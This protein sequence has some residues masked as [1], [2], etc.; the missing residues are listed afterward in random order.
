MTVQ[1]YLQTP[2]MKGERNDALFRAVMTARREGLSEIEIYHQLTQKALSDGLSESEIRSTINSGMRTPMDEKRP[3]RTRKV[4]DWDSIIGPG[5]LRREPLALPGPASDWET[6]DFPRF[7]NALF[8][9]DEYVSYNAASKEGKPRG[10]GKYRQTRSKLLDR[11]KDN[12]TTDVVC[13][14]D[15]GAW[16]R[17]NPMDGEGIKDANVT[18]YR[19]TLVESDELSIEEQWRIMNVLRVPCSTVVHSGNKSLHFAVKVDAQDKNEYRRRVNKLHDVLAQHGFVSDRQNRN[20]SRLSRLPGVYRHGNPQYLVAVDLGADTFDDWLDGIEMEKDGLPPIETGVSLHRNPP[21]MSKELIEGV[22]RKGHKMLL[23]GPSKT[24]KT[25]TMIHLACALTAGGIW[26]GFPC[27]KAS[28]L[29]LNME[30]DRA[31]FW[32]RVEVVG[33]QVGIDYDGIEIWNLRGHSAPLN[34]LA[35]HLIRRVVKGKYDAIII[36]PAYKTLMGDENSASDMA[37]FCNQMDRI[38]ETLGASV[39]YA[40]HYSKGHQGAKEAIDRPSGSG[41][42]GRDPDAICTMTPL[43]GPGDGIEME[44]ILREF[45]KPDNTYLEWEYPTHKVNSQLAE[46]KT[47]GAKGR[48]KK[49]FSTELAG[50][51]RDLTGGAKLAPVDEVLKELDVSRRTFDRRIKG[52]TGVKLINGMVHI[53]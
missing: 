49:L 35:G 48:T 17:L 18:A 21:P 36:D 30:I 2:C 13:S 3:R 38:A 51:V 7:L 20:P 28:V 44:W 23:A 26:Y 14:E 47:K 42:L 9:A 22:L 52:M 40:T 43:E 15:D 39:I 53:T 11:H 37:A 32:N 8:R 10:Y 12:H 16:V 41:V 45:V 4:Y 24:R 31:S 19:H 6:E 27:K 29:Y 25:F 34:I 1:D 50:V 46:R 33:N 5:S